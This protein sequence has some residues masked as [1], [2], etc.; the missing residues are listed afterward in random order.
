M[1]LPQHLPTHSVE[2][3]IDTTLLLGRPSSTI[4]S[5]TSIAGTCN[6]FWTMSVPSVI[7]QFIFAVEP[8]STFRLRACICSLCHAM[9]PYMAVAVTAPTK[10]SISTGRVGAAES[11]GSS[12]R[13]NSVCV[14]HPGHWARVGVA[15]NFWS[16]YI[17]WLPLIGHHIISVF[18]DILV[19]TSFIAV[20]Q[21]WSGLAI[22]SSTC[23]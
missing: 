2:H 4:P 6:L 20:G 11:M 9:L 7:Q 14:W 1:C 8:L 12:S 21:C 13:W 15:G 22:H 5:P 23:S 19:C 17:T 16:N 3:P 18:S 10:R